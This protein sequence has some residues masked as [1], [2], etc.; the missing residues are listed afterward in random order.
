MGA[1]CH[2]ASFRPLLVLARRSASARRHGDAPDSRGKTEGSDLSI[3]IQVGYLK[4]A[5]MAGRPRI[6]FEGG[7]YHVITRGN[8][9]QKVFL[10]EKAFLK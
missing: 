2:R 6:E 8:Q 4:Y 1:F 5:T 3:D 7:F 10:E 9:R